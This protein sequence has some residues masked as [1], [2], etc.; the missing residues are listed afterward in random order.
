VGIKKKN[1]FVEKNLKGRMG[2]ESH[3]KKAHRRP[4][5]SLVA[6][7]NKNLL[8]RQKRRSKMTALALSSKKYSF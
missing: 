3:R 4:S 7:C 2:G 1:R 6:F 5:S 8:E